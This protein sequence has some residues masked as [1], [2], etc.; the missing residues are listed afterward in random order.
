MP[1]TK[2][3][4]LIVIGG[5]SAGIT[6]VTMGS[7]LGARALLVDRESLGGDCLHYGCVPSKSLIASAR[8]AH[9]LRNADVF[10]LRATAPQVNFS[11]V[12][13]RVDSIRDEIGSHET[14]EVIRELGVDVSLGGA[15]FVDEN[16]IEIGSS[17]RVTADK[18]LI[19]TGSYA[20]APDIPGLAENGFID[21]V[22]LFG[23]R[24]LPPRL[25][26][27][28]GGAIGTEMGQ[29]LSRLG[30]DVTIIQRA[31]RLLPREDPAVSAVLHDAFAAEGIT[32]KLSA[33]PVCVKRNGM[34]KDVVIEQ[35]GQTPVLAL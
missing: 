23:L 29:A 25:V 31:S 1:E 17:D 15:S 32:L 22:G 4:D 10:G 21:H 20:V 5:G 24:E 12:M 14:P 28:G 18:I 13:D 35:D 16:T 26:V 19:A 6:A 34:Q 33:S 27:I 30:S 7:R 11:A 3:Y 9:T 2:H 8:A